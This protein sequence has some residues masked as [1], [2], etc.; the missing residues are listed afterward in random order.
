MTGLKQSTAGFR[1]PSSH[2]LTENELAWIAF[3][4]LITDD[5]D[6]VPTLVRIQAFR[7]AWQASGLHK[8]PIESG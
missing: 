3:L 2:P 6:P 8:A 7:Q 5:T 4:R 1:V